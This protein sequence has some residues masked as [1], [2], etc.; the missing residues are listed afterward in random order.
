MYMYISC[1]Y[2]EVGQGSAAWEVEGEQGNAGKVRE[3]WEYKKSGAGGG[4][5]SAA[6]EAGRG[7]E[8]G[9]GEQEGAGE[10]CWG[11]RMRQGKRAGGAGGVTGWE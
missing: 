11:S 6:G 2:Q 5:G 8:R 3:G 7:R 4:Q 1:T 9:Q 10:C